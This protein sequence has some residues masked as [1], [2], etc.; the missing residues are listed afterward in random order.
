MCDTHKVM[1]IRF[2]AADVTHEITSSTWT[3]GTV[4][5]PQRDQRVLVQFGSPFLGVCGGGGL[6]HAERL[7]AVGAGVVRDVVVQLMSRDH[8]S[9]DG[10]AP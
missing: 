2:P 10:Q 4:P 6:G 3:F 9:G 1:G 7:H 8:A 5:V